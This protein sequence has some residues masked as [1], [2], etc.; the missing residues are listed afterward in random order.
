MRK[1][2]AGLHHSLALIVTVLFF[3]PLFWA[4]VNSLRAVGAPPPN[5]VE[6][7]PADAH[8]ENFSQIFE[9]LPVGRYLVN[10]LIVVGLAIPIT[11]V[12]ASLA[13]FSI[14]QL[15]KR[16]RRYLLF[17]CIAVMMIPAASVWL[18]RFQILRWLGLIDTLWALI[19]PAFAA[20]QGGVYEIE[21]ATDPGLNN[22]VDS[23]SVSDL[24]YTPGTDLSTSTVYF[25]RVRSINACGD[26]DFSAPYRFTT[27]GAPG[28]C[29][30][31][32]EPVVYFEEDFEDTVSGWTSGGT[33]NTWDLSTERSHSPVQSYFA[34]DISSVSDQRLVSPE[35]QLPADENP[36]TLQFWNWQELEGFG[37]GCFDGAI[38][39]IT[40]DSGG[41]WNQIPNSALLTD[42]YD[43]PV[44]SSFSNPLADLDAWC[45]DP[46]D[47]LESVVD[48][49]AYAGETVQFRFRVGTDSSVSREG[50]YIDDMVVQSCQISNFPAYL[51]LVQDGE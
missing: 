1:I 30:L 23:G 34:A 21:I 42:P 6:W 28:D 29:G 47:W 3:L 46:Q 14:A 35:I 50:W 27:V 12:T 48:L 8:W 2:R 37:S 36:L 11:L 26:G 24:T 16:P 13:G 18:A 45:G 20:S 7:W 22:V 40:T 32:S 38:L 25:W 19:V 43:G 15:P 31:G 4:L 9:V 17:F 39:E 51:P 5:T 41:N 44:S 33:A 10:S 49:N